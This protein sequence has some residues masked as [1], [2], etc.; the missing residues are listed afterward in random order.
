MTVNS[1]D[2]FV[3][4]TTNKGLLKFNNRYV[5]KTEFAKIISKLSLAALNNKIEQ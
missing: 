1:Q 3:E 5:E 4:I 2:G